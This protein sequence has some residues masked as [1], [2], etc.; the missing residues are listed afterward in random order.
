MVPSVAVLLFI[1]VKGSENFWI[2][3]IDV[4]TIH[5]G[6]VDDA[7]QPLC[8]ASAYPDGYQQERRIQAFSSSLANSSPYIYM[9]EPK[10]EPWQQLL[11]F[12]SSNNP[13]P[14][15]AHMWWLQVMGA[16][17]AG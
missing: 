16:A 13:F 1:A 10:R 7:P 11:R 5:F 9:L 3:V 15:S 12:T 6:K 4:E 17:H 8:D 2:M 14:W